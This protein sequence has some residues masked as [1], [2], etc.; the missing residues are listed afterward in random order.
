MTASGGLHAGVRPRSPAA[1]ELA[2]ATFNVENLDPSDPPDK[3]DA[4]GR[5]DRR[6]TCKSPDIVA[7]GGDPGRRTA[8]ANN[9]VVDGGPITWTRSCRDPCGRRP[10]VRATGRSTP[11][12]TQDGGEPGGNIRVGLPLP[13]RPRPRASSTAPAADRDHARRGWSRAR[14]GAAAAVQPGPDRPDQ[15]GVR[16]SRKPLVGE[17]RAAARRSSSIVNHFNS[18]G[19]DDPLFGR[20]QPP[21]R[22]SGDPAARTGADRQRLR[23]R[24]SS[25]S[26]PTPTSS[27]SATSTTSSSPRRVSILEARRPRGPA[28]RRCQRAERYTLRV[29]RQLAGARPDPGQ[30]ALERDLIAYDVVHVNSE[31]ADQASDHEP[32][33]ARFLFKP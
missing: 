21:N 12:T 20:F 4:A 3:F 31:F 25:P 28:S 33:V 23:R 19:G 8:P 14:H 32:Q 11:S 26:T 24:A 5:A 16:R 10:G 1:N 22:V 27:S 17:F 15:P 13:H 7:P 29:R 18:K 9:G 2:V 30:P 6:T